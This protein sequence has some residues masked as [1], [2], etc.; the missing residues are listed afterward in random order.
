MDNTPESALPDQIASLT[1]AL[2]QQ[3]EAF[4]KISLDLVDTKVA[5]GSRIADLDDGR[6]ETETRLESAWQARHDALE[7]KLKSQAMTSIG[8]VL[9]ALLLAIALLV[10]RRSAALS[11]ADESVH[12]TLAGLQASLAALS[13]SITQGKS[14]TSPPTTHKIAVEDYSPASPHGE[15][16]QATLVETSSLEATPPLSGLFDSDGIPPAVDPIVVA[17][18]ADPTDRVSA[19]AADDP[20]ATSADAVPTPLDAVAADPTDSVSAPGAD[21]PA[22]AGADAVP[23]RLDAEAVPDDADPDPA[24]TEDAIA[25]ARPTAPPELDEQQILVGQRPFAVQLMGFYSLDA[26]R[27]FAASARLPSR[28]YFREE[29]YRG[30]PWFVLIHSLYPTRSD[31]LKAM[32]MF[33]AELAGIDVWIRSLPPEALLAVLKTD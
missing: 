19:P 23:G 28:V 25:D 3:K 33:P 1:D 20:A 32:A 10:D 17:A 26:M 9:L 5:L 27:D 15:P 21:D 2:A 14:Q 30:R 13:E 22:L 8:L 16:A 12:E 11:P 6:R 24:Y 31:A 7:T 29:R 4:A 18:G